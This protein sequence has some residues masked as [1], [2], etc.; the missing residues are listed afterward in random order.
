MPT[1]RSRSFGASVRRLWG[2]L[3][4]ERPRMVLI[5]V[6]ALATTA[7]NVAGPKLLGQATDVVIEGV[8]TPAGID[9]DALHR[10]L[11]E[12]GAVYALAAALGVVIAY[13]LAGVV[14]RLNYRLRE[15]A[16]AKLNAL[17]LAYV[18]SQPRG[19]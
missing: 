11:L 7:L 13:T 2:L 17:P 15:Q 12:V 5:V 16:E 1:E 18:D 8:T 19:D 9:F 6:L 4:P 3:R 14:Q 10:T